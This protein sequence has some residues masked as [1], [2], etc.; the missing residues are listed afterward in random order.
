MHTKQRFALLQNSWFRL[1]D[2][3]RPNFHDTNVNYEVTILIHPFVENDQLHRQGRFIFQ[4]K[5]HRYT[6]ARQR[7]L[8][9]TM[10][11]VCSG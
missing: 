10:L 6:V 7:F 4:K 11:Q 3:A 1:L 5:H 9:Q 8:P 2:M